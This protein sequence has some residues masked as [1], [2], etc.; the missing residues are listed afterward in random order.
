MTKEMLDKLIEQ[1]RW[2]TFDSIHPGYH[3][4]LLK[5]LVE[6]KNIQES[7]EDCISR[8]AVLAMSDYIGE[9]PTYDNPLG[10]VE[11]VV[12]VKDIMALPS[13][14]PA[15]KKGKPI[16]DIDSQDWEF[17]RP[18]KCPFCNERLDYSNHYCHNCGAEMEIEEE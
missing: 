12:R 6:L 11:E 8:E 15:R 5:A 3:N 17:N 4:E 14:A 9:T 16:Y 13:V 7:C 1:E 18:I 2:E 10:E